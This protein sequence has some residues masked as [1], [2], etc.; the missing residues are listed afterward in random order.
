MLERE[1]AA[2]RVIPS[3]LIALNQGEKTERTPGAGVILSVSEGSGGMG[4]TQHGVISRLSTA[5][6]PSAQILR[7]RSG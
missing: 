4:G 7:S 1:L 5:Y 2:A 6:H 3:P